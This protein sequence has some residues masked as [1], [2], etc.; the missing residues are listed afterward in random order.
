MRIGLFTHSGNARGGVVHALSVGDALAAAG[1][2][3]SLL[4]PLGERGF[5]RPSHGRTVA[6][7]LATEGRTGSRERVGQQ[8][9]LIARFLTAPGAP[10]YDVWHAGDP[11]TANA[12]G[13]LVRTGAIGG[14]SR[15]VHHLDSF[16]DPR[17]AAWQESGL[18]DAAALCCV[19]QLYQ[20]RLAAE[21]GRAATLVGNGV[22]TAR[23]SPLP[24]PADVETRERWPAGGPRL[25]ALGGVE[26]RKN[27]LGILKGFALARRSLPAATLLIAGGASLLDHAAYG[28]QFQAALADSGLAGAVRVCGVVPEAEMPAL[29]RAADMLLSPSLAEGFGL[30]AVEATACATPAIVAARPPFTEHLAPGDCLFVDPEDHQAIA[31]A[32]VAATDPALSAALRRRGPRIAAR[33]AWSAVAR[34]HLPVFHALQESRPQHA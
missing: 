6:L 9:D 16:T 1:H 2:E 23:F 27:T 15:T 26:P 5:F 28:V 25:L 32:I 8:I 13:A 17:L 19:S 34:R 12:L 20:A 21:F 31:R 3:V 29:Y 24:G 30:A 22:D 11:I 14:F 4:A 7:P 33:F 10:R 18:R